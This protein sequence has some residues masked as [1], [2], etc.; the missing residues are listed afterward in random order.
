VACRVQSIFFKA[1]ELEDIINRVRK[2]ELGIVYIT[3]T[4]GLRNKVRELIMG[5]VDFTQVENFD[6]LYKVIE[7]AGGVPG[8]YE[9]YNPS[10]LKEIIDKVRNGEVWINAV[11]RT[12]GLRDKVRELLKDEIEKNKNNV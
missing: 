7:Q 5:N 2:G 11:T 9:Y 6:D 4:G 8:S 10:R 3:R 1:S 12:A